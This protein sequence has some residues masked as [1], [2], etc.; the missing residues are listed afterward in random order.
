MVDRNNTNQ[1]QKSFM[2]DFAQFVCM[3]IIYVLLLVFTL[4]FTG[5]D[6]CNNRRDELNQI[7][8]IGDEPPHFISNFSL[9]NGCVITNVP[10]K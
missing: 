8:L 5:L 2:K 1:D 3:T 4:Y 10:N 6:D 7:N 9:F